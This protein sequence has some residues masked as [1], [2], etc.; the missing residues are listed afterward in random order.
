MEQVTKQDLWDGL[1]IL[2]VFILLLVAGLAFYIDRQHDEEMILL[3]EINQK[4]DQRS[5]LDNAYKEHLG[6]CAMLSRDNI[7]VDKKGIIRSFYFNG[8]AKAQ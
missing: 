7:Y 6:Q 8:S 2:F 5:V 4:I 1:T 3:E